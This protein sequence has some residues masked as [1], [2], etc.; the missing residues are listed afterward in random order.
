MHI[1]NNTPNKACDPDSCSFKIPRTKKELAIL[2]SASETFAFEKSFVNCSDTALR[3]VNA[4]LI[5][6]QID[7]YGYSAFK[8]EPHE[9]D[10]IPIKKL[11]I[12]ICFEGKMRNPEIH[13]HGEGI[14]GPQIKAFKKRA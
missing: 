12:L 3:Q 2:Q 13:P 14:D 11:A 5:R 10:R 9:Y 1:S 6:S 7:R 8:D 4:E